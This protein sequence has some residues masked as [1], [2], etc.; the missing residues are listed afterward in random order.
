[1]EPTRQSMSERV[2]ERLNREPETVYQLANNRQLAVTREDGV[3]THFRFRDAH[4][5]FA[6]LDEMVEEIL[7]TTPIIFRLDEGN[8]ALIR[9]N[10][11]IAQKAYKTEFYHRCDFQL[12]TREAYYSFST[13]DLKDKKRQCLAKFFVTISRPR[14]EHYDELL[15]EALMFVRGQIPHMGKFPETV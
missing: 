8:L 4:A 6:L 11:A 10:M 7:I 12:G 9:M 2:N 1:M 13:K 14:P 15:T 3:E 5:A